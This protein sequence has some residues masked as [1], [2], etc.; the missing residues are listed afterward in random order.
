M[1]EAPSNLALATQNLQPAPH[2]T[3][4]VIKT[5]VGNYFVIVHGNGSVFWPANNKYFGSLALANEFFELLDKGV[6]PSAV[7][8]VHKG[9]AAILYGTILKNAPKEVQD[10]F[11]HEDLLLLGKYEYVWY[12]M[13]DGVYLSG[14]TAKEVYQEFEWKIDSASITITAIFD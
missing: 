14:F 1:F 2:G 4:H 11:V 8:I 5:A 12:V 3:C 10:F 7:P 6:T 9:Q 13:F